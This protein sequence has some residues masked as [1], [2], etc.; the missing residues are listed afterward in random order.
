MQFPL[1]QR[2]SFFCRRWFVFL[3]FG[4]T[5]ALFYACTSSGSGGDGGSENEGAPTESTTSTTN[6]TGDS[7]SS[8][9]SESD[10]AASPIQYTYRVINTFPHDREAFT[11]GLVVDDGIL[12]EG[13][14]LRG[15]SNLRVVTLD[16][17]EVVRQ[18][19]LEDQFF[20]EG[21]AIFGDQV[22]QLT[23]QS[24]VGFVYDKNSF[25]KLREFEYPN[26]GWGITHDGTQWIMSAGTE[27]LYFMDSQ[28]FER[29]GEVDVKDGDT[30]ITSL[31][32]LEYI[33]GEV[34]ANVW[35]TD[36]VVR[37]DPSTGTVVG[38]VNLSGLLTAADLETPV[39]VLNGIAYDADS[40]RL[41][42]TGKLWPKLFEIEVVPIN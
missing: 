26:E 33:Q 30:A 15:S 4:I 5:V 19:D 17:G 20:G 8:S 32:E 6:S 13:T 18:L 23:W 34:W 36:Q 42:V 28:T 29:T 24:Q 14:G 31:N 21:I 2:F 39:D 11:Q 12:Y 37:I 22:V 25:T 41:F 10:A 27:K 3:V 35:Q 1:K 16:T 38:W 9:E 7:G 40:N